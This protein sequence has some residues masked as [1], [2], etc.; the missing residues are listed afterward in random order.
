MPPTTS[1]HDS[2]AQPATHQGAIIALRAILTVQGLFLL[3][4]LVSIFGEAMLCR[5]SI[6]SN[7]FFPLDFTSACLHVLEKYNDVI[8]RLGSVIN[9]ALLPVLFILWFVSGMILFTGRKT[10]G[11][12]DR[13]KFF[14]LTF[15]YLTELALPVVAFIGFITVILMLAS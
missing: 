3:T 1:S 5:N 8:P 12:V 15:I 13:K 6:L 4:Y 11:L 2:V 10:W 7:I 9:T 14:I